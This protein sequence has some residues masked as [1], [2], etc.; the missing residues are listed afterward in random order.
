MD[1]LQRILLLFQ[2]FFFEIY[3]GTSWWCFVYLQ[4]K[5]CRPSLDSFSRG[6]RIRQIKQWIKLYHR[7]QETWRWQLSHRRG[8]KFQKKKKIKISRNLRRICKKCLRIKVVRK[9]ILH[10]VMVFKIQ[11]FMYIPQ[12]ME[13]IEKF[14]FFLISWK[15]IA[16]QKFRWTYWM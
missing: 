5:K 4:R 2:F 14:R 11:W 9:V 12:E 7:D 1:F 13:I 3:P 10:P 8:P 16:P 6:K 15:I